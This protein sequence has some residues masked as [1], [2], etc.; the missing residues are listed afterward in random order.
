MTGEKVENKGVS[1]SEKMF[2]GIVLTIIGLFGFGF[3]GF[4]LGGMMYM[5][6]YRFGYGYPNY[7]YTIS[8]IVTFVSLGITLFGL[9]LIYDS[10]RE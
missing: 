1:K 4:G 7:F 8:I 5:M 2:A 6:G 9:Y 3:G 10:I